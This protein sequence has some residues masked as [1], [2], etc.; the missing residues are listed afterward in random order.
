MKMRVERDV[1]VGSTYV[2]LS[3]AAVHRTIEL[4]DLVLVDLDESGSVVGIDLAVDVRQLS[5]RETRL[6]CNAFPSVAVELG[7][8]PVEPHPGEWVPVTQ[9]FSDLSTF[10]ELFFTSSR[11]VE[12][13]GRAID[14]PSGNSVRPEALAS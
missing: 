13:R 9:Q 8:R 1:E 11:F 12:P 6:L 4:D 2:T 10:I 3:D 14:S 7:L 5:P